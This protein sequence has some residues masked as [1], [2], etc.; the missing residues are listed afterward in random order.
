MERMNMKNIS[1]KKAD[2]KTCTDLVEEMFLRL[3]LKTRY[4]EKSGV[5]GI[6]RIKKQN[7]KRNNTA[8]LIEWFFK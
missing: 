6:I 2:K 1:N 7:L 4:V 8:N 3:G 5:V